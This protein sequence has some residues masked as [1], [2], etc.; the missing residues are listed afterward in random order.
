MKE[1]LYCF[2]ITK[3]ITFEVNYYTLGNNTSAYFATS[4]NEFIRSKRDYC[5]GGQAQA[6]LLPKGS[7]A[8]RF[9]TKWDPCHL[10]D[11]TAEQYEEL[12]ADIEELK[13]RYNYIVKEADTFQGTHA[14]LS[15]YSIVELSKLQ[16]KKKTA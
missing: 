12:T 15:F 14:R 5:R 11:L 3:L 8:R 13:A 10:H 2:Q 6:A 16:P 4:A 1:F 7:T 9:W